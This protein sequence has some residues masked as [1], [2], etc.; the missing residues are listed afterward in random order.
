MLG[1]RIDANQAVVPT[2]VSNLWI[3]PA[4]N[5]G[6]TPAELLMNTRFRQALDTYARTYDLVIIDT[7]PVLD[8]NDAMAVSALAAATVMV[9]RTGAHTEEQIVDAVKRLKRAGGNVVGGILNTV[10]GDAVPQSDS[11]SDTLAR[12][13]GQPA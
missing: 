1:G 12:A 7:P 11:L 4:G 8:H 13:A 5:F 9:L 10:V 6:A 2:G 3:V